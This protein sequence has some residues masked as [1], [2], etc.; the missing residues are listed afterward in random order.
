MKAFKILILSIMLTSCSLDS[1]CLRPDTT[2]KYG[3][4]LRHE[5]RQFYKEAVTDFLVG[6]KD[7]KYEDLVDFGQM[8]MMEIFDTTI[9][10]GGATFPEGGVIKTIYS[11]VAQPSKLK[12]WLKVR[13]HSGWEEIDLRKYFTR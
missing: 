12:I 5:L 10:Q 11:V 6:E 8:K 1:L 9:P 7:S 3:F 2:Y 13:N 4:L